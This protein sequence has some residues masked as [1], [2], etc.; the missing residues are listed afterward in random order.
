L[1]AEGEAWRSGRRIAAPLFNP[2]AIALLFDDMR[3]ATEA[4]VERWRD[5]DEISTPMDLASEFQRLTYEIVSRTVFSGALD[6]DRVRVHANMAIYFD[7]LGRIDLASVINLPTWVPTPANRRARP[8]LKV[9]RGVVDR[10]VAARVADADR[11]VVDLLDRLMRAP[12]PTTGETLPPDAVSDNMLTFLAAGHE[13]TGNALAWILYLLALYPGSESAV[14]EEMAAV[15]ERGPMM[16]ERFDRLV[17]TRAWS[18]RR[19]GSIR[20]RRSSAARRSKTTPSWSI[21][22]RQGRRS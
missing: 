2:R 11:K 1:T 20:R 3:H 4:M 9:F 7:T 18:T 14:L 12:D 10:V 21:R 6:D 8:A 13:T 16:R 22:W 5:R 17:F 15:F 19:C